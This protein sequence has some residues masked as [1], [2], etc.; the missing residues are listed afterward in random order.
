MISTDLTSSDHDFLLDRLPLW[1]LIPKSRNSRKIVNQ[2]L[3]DVVAEYWEVQ[4][5]HRVVSER[6]RDKISFVS[7]WCYSSQ[8]YD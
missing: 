7:I 6:G 3:N 8:Q 5:N 4:G 2:F 1:R